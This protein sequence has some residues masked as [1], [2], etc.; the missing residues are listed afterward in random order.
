MRPLNTIAH[1]SPI[2]NVDSRFDGANTYILC[3]QV[4]WDD[5]TAFTIECWI[6][7]T[8][9]QT[10]SLLLYTQSG[11]RLIGIFNVSN[12]NI[13]VNNMQ[14]SATGINIVPDD[15]WHFFS[16]TWNSVGGVVAIYLDGAVLG[17]YTNISAN[18]PVY[19]GGAFLLGQK[20]MPSLSIPIYP[21]P[22]PDALKGHV[23]SFRLWNR[24]RQTYFMK[25]ER[26][27]TLTGDQSQTQWIA[28][29]Q[30][31]V[32]PNYFKAVFTSIA[33]ADETNMFATDTLG[34][35]W[36]S[37]NYGQSWSKPST[38]L[39]TMVSASSPSTGSVQAVGID[40]T[41]APYYSGNKG[42]N[43]SKANTAITLKEVSI[44][45]MY[46]VGTNSSNQPYYSTNGGLDWQTCGSTPMNWMASDLNAIW[47]LDAGGKLHKSANKLGTDWVAVTPASGVSPNFVALYAYNNYLV[48]IGVDPAIP[49]HPVQLMYLSADGG[50]HWQLN[51][52][53]RPLEFTAG[54]LLG[55]VVWGVSPPGDNP[56][57]D[58]THFAEADTK[59]VLHWMLDEGYGNVAY[60]DSN[61]G[62]DGV[63][64]SILDSTHPEW[65]ISSMLEPPGFVINP[66]EA[67]I[68]VSKAEA[69]DPNTQKAVEKAV[70]NSWNPFTD[71][72]LA[73]VTANAG[74]LGLAAPPVQAGAV[75]Q[76]FAAPAAI[77]PV[78]KATAVKKA[79]VVKKAA[80][81]KKA[82]VKKT[83]AKAAPKK[84]IKKK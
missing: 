56:F 7:A 59:M 40:S 36:Y 44:V 78:K 15:D 57:N 84:P 71:D 42:T 6:K 65:D 64:G 69:A 55:N 54:A 60:D 35:V 50:Q 82:P 32:A 74:P 34:N 46:A 77:P 19:A 26:L 81:A 29:M 62:N 27:H 23:S 28:V 70:G 73:P 79:A 67:F 4:V 61:H 47:G 76:Q 20:T 11:A 24:V 75:A 13:V 10:G 12:L 41:G 58:N 66:L 48:G 31:E 8:P 83:T 18:M 17:T 80:P 1:F 49:N 33:P 16:L 52:S 72:D 30:P 68:P 3:D 63:L 45:G 51:N 9:G 14:T 43:W 37:T 21:V 2:Y 39:L 53:P 22:N 38:Q 5:L 25:R